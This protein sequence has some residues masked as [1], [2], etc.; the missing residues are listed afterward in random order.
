[1]GTTSWAYPGWSGIVYGPSVPQKDLSNY[2]LTAYAKHPLFRTVEIDRT[3]YEPVLATG[4]QSYASQVPEDFRFLMKAHEDCVV[5]QFPSHPRYGKKRGET[6]SRYLDA[7]YATDKVVG[8]FVEGLGAKGGALLFQFPPHAV[9]DPEAFAGELH[10]F[11]TRLPKGVVYA[12]EIRNA[13]LFVPAYSNALEDAGAVHC[14]NVW[15]RMPT[16]TAQAKRISPRAR[17]PFVLRW[18]LRPNDTYERAN[19]RYSP[20]SRVVEQDETTLTL[21]ASIL[22]KVH[23]HGIEAFVLVDNKAEGCAPESVARLARAIVDASI[24]PSAPSTREHPEV[25]STPPNVRPR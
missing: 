12:V 11:L 19:A 17:R 22:A 23:L 14:H 2:G 5:R 6:N 7:A 8:P 21:A 4:L 3:Y 13:E 9:D 24:V 16:L 25:P 10:A 18:L 15:T 20:F 1:M